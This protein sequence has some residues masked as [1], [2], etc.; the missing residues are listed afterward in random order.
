[1][2]V[3]ITQYLCEQRHCILAVAWEDNGEINR[4][5]VEEALLEQAGEMKLNPWCGLCGSAQLHFETAPTRFP[6]LA[7]AL[8]SLKVCEAAQALTR[9]HFANQPKPN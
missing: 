4:V 8:P 6:T 7:E 2:K 3:N 9:D 1:M 5:W